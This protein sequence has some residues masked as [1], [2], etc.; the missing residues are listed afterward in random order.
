[1]T[2]QRL[3][4]QGAVYI[5]VPGN[6]PT[7]CSPAILTFRLSPNRADYDHIGCLRAVNAVA[8]YHNLLLRA[9]VGG[10]RGRYPHARIVF[11]DFYDPIIRILENP[12]HF[13]NS[14]DDFHPGCILPARSRRPSRC[15][16]SE[17]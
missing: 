14:T 9:A 3:I 16:R 2:P 8:R 10:L 12:G 5:V 11:A 17:L 4:N 1:L 6:P 15:C 7:G 13:G